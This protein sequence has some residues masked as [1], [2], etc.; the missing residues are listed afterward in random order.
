MLFLAI[1]MNT[2]YCKWCET[3]KAV[4]DFHKH[5]KMKD[6]RLNKC[7]KCVQE[8]VSQW[9]KNNPGCRQK[10]YLRS[11]QFKN[12]KYSKQHPNPNWT[13]KD[14]LQSKKR[15][16]RLSQAKRN[17][18]E[19]QSTPAWYDSKEVGYI[20]SLAQEKDLVVDHIV[21]LN[22]KFVCGLNVQDNLRCIPYLLN[23]KKGNH[24]WP[25]MAKEVTGY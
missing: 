17:A 10:E 5:K 6:G 25:N 12:R 13:E 8:S 19:R 14:R 9:R 21:P 23:C 2:K 20:Y 3:K 4:T 24:Y 11:N 16:S 1:D 15:S 18:A 22:S 7:A